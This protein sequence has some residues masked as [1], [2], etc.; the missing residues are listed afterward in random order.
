M[1]DTKPNGPSATLENPYKAIDT[2]GCGL[3][4]PGARINSIVDA[5]SINMLMSMHPRPPGV[6]KTTINIIYDKLI[7]ELKRRGIT[8]I[9]RQSDFIAFMRECEIGLPGEQLRPAERPVSNGAVAG[10]VPEANEPTNGRG[11]AAD[12]TEASR[13]PGQQGNVQP[14]GAGKRRGKGVAQDRSV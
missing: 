13:I 11:A 3:G 12:H 8:T 9:D 7:R 2:L 1:T 6:I 4:L 10:P 14:A 5:S